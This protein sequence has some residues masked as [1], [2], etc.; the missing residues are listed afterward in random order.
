MKRWLKVASWAAALLAVALLVSAV[1]RVASL[2]LPSD[3]REHASRGPSRIYSQPLVLRPRAWV[4]AD[5]LEAQLQGAGYRQVDG[6]PQRPGEYARDGGRFRID[7]RAFRDAAGEEPGG[8]VRVAISPEGRVESLA[9]AQGELEVVR[10]EGVPL[11]GFFPKSGRDREPVRLDRL[12]A[13]VVDAVLA[14]EDQRFFDHPGFDLRRT[15]GAM[16]SNLRAGRVVEGGSTLTQQLA[17]NLYLTR[18]RTLWRKLQELPLALLLEA[19]LDKREILEAYCNE[20]YF[21]QAGPVAIHGVASAARHFFGKRP[22]ELRLSEAALLAGLLRGPILYEPRRAPELA[23]ARRDE[24]LARMREQGRID[25]AAYVAARAEP[26]GV[27]EPWSPP[28]S[29]RWFLDGVRRE[30]QE[31]FHDVDL[32]RAGWRFDTTLDLRL[33]RLAERAVVRGVARIEER[34]PKLVRPESPLQAALVALDPK[35][36]AVLALVGGRDYGATQ[37]D[38]AREAHRQPGSLFKPVAALAALAPELGEPPRFTLATLLDDEPFAMD[39]PEGPWQPHNHDAQFRGPVTLRQAIEHS[40]NVPMVR[41]GQLVGPRRIVRAARLLGIESPLHAVPSLVLGTSETTLLEMT[42]AFGVL[43]A[44]GWRADLRTLVMARDADGAIAL[45]APPQGA[46]ALDPALAYVVTS[47]LRGVVDH[48]TGAAVRAHGYQGPLAG[49]TGTTD[50]YRDAWFV[51]YTPEL[52]AGVWLGFD[53]G[54]SLRQSASRAALPVFAEF[55][56]GALGPSGGRDFPTPEGVEQIRVVAAPGHPAG[57]RCGGDPEVFLEGTGPYE[58]CEPWEWLDDAGEVRSIGD[59]LRDQPW[60]PGRRL[61]QVAAP[62][63]APR[64][65]SEGRQ[66]EPDSD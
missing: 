44:R 50:E 1:V 25:E 59:W 42:R 60:W 45:E 51:G 6:R 54:A 20:V 56:R 61:P 34:T 38:R 5:D 35:S 40:L 23:R 66:P 48:G 33:Q 22:E 17:K 63:P 36:G 24:V 15:A 55:A 43:A 65:A 29:A 46:H 19:K 47:V 12:P 14:I 49:K 39:T 28:S 37:F 64:S 4:E 62:P 13:H 3:P 26:L 52:V 2:E 57:L 27:R 10:I 11:G 7:A 8:R 53:D 30:I 32:A 58:G 41:L 16:I 18:E 21:G 31:R 9:D